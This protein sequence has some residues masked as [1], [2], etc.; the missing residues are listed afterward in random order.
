MNNY[1][2]NNINNINECIPSPKAKI[3]L[4][5]NNLS[6]TSKDFYTKPKTGNM[7]ILSCKKNKI[8][9][10]EDNNISTRFKNIFIKKKLQ[11]NYFSHNKLNSEKMNKRRNNSYSENI[12]NSIDSKNNLNKDIYTNINEDNNISEIINKY[13][14]NNIKTNCKINSSDKKRLVGSERVNNNNM[15]NELYLHK[16]NIPSNKVKNTQK[17]K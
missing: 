10:K 7:K 4:T 8:F 14:Y 15:P 3:K 12:I 1:I 11:T 2:N 5:K 6:R 16:N 17:K 9:N 13:K